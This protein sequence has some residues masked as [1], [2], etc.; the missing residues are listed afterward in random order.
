MRS[1][2]QNKVVGGVIVLLSAAAFAGTAKQGTGAIKSSL[3]TAPDSESI[4][5]GPSLPPD[6]WEGVRLAHGPSLPPDPW[7]GLR[8][9]H[10]PSLPPDPWEGL[11]LAHGPSLPPDP[12][13]GLRLT[14]GPSLPPILGKACTSTMVRHKKRSVRPLTTRKAASLMPDRSDT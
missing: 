9:A 4:M 1:I 8:L 11:R 2:F 5:H 10:G 7:E 14:H 3:L 13:E 12:W 6:P